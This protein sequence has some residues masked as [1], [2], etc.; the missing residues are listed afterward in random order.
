MD[1]RCESF[2]DRVLQQ[3]RLKVQWAYQ[4]VGGKAKSRRVLRVLEFN[5]QKLAD[6]LTPEALGAMLGRY[7]KAE[8]SRK[9]PTLFDFGGDDTDD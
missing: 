8:A 5:G 3:R 1:S 9:G 7:S 6:A 2:E 4:V